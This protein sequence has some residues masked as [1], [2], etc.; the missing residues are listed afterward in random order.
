MA[1]R[2]GWGG[3]KADTHVHKLKSD[4]EY[5]ALDVASQHTRIKQLFAM[6]RTLAEDVRSMQGA[7]VTTADPTK[8]ESA[9]KD[10]DQGAKP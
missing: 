4:V 1:K 8:S 5:M 10:S 2:K 6:V 3:L 7:F 9:D